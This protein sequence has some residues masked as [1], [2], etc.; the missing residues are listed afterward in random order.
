VGEW[1]KENPA[2]LPGFFMPPL[3][4]LNGQCVLP[5]ELVKHVGRGVAVRESFSPSHSND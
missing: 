1:E 5:G 3:I 4:W 2:A